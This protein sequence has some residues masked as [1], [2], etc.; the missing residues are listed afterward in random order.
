LWGVV[1]TGG[2]GYWLFTKLKKQSDEAIV[3]NR[4]VFPEAARNWEN[5]FYCHRCENVFVPAAV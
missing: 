1:I 3:Y 2:F 4:D 5:G